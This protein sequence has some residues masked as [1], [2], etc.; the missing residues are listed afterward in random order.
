MSVFDISNYFLKG[1]SL[2]FA[3]SF[4]ATWL[5]TLGL[6]WLGLAYHT[7][8]QLHSTELEFWSRVKSCSQHV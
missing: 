8:S 1:S 6:T 7:T 5:I 4:G 2:S 3:K